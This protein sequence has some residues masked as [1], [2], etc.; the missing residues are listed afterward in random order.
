MDNLNV[1]C[2]MSPTQGFHNFD[3][4]PSLKISRSRLLRTTARLFGLLSR[5]QLNY[6]DFASKS[7]IRFGDVVSGLPV[8]ANS[9]GVFYSSHTLEHLDTAEAEAFCREA[10]RVLS[11]GGIIRL[12]VPDL[13]LVISDYLTHR[14][15]DAFMRATLLGT[16]RPIG[17]RARA[18]H[19]FVGPRHHL[20]MYDGASLVRL[21]ERHGFLDAQVVPAGVTTILNPGALDLAERS[22]ESVY[23]E[24]RKPVTR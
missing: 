6:I 11:P 16:N 8:A 21:L 14:D 20:W 19:A 17:F 12:A 7:D 10:M 3:N 15:A 23:V 18:A 9:V 2:G 22:G 1:G 24:A 5:S 4:S 13:N